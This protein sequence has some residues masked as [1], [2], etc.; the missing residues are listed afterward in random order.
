[1]KYSLVKEL[2]AKSL[3]D[4]TQP[5]PAPTSC[6]AKCDSSEAVTTAEGRTC[7]CDSVCFSYGDCCEDRAVTCGGPEGGSCQNHCGKTEAAPGSTP[8]NLCYC[9]TGCAAR[10][11]CCADYGNA[12]GG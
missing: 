6:P 5:P 11:D 12:C 8:P 9:D 1:V 3:I 4:P 2:L 7:Y 10:G